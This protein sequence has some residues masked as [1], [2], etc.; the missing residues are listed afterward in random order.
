MAIKLDEVNKIL[1]AYDIKN[2][3]VDENSKEILTQ[4]NNLIYAKIKSHFKINPQYFG[5]HIN[6][7]TNEEDEYLDSLE[8]A[9]IIKERSINK[10]EST[11]IITE[12]EMF[13]YLKNK[14]KSSKV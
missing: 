7:Y 9:N 8:I 14:L 12:N 3:I 4:T 13:N 10:N 5:L 6:H 2:D 1:Y 11:K